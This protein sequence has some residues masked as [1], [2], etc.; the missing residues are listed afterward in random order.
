[1]TLPLQVMEREQKKFKEILGEVAVRTSS[2]E[3]FN[4][5]VY[6]TIEVNY[7]DSSKLSISS[8]VY[9]QGGTTVATL[10]QSTDTTKDTWV[11]S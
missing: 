9:K 10:T 1:M 7:T 2:V 3:G 8:V 11:R 4:L 5:P 6:D